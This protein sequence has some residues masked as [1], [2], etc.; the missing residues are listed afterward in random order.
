MDPVECA[1]P[2]SQ[3]ASGTDEEREA[4]WGEASRRAKGFNVRWRDFM[5]ATSAVVQDMLA[6]GQYLEESKAAIKEKGGDWLDVFDPQKVEEPITFG[7][8]TRQAAIRKA[9]SLMLIHRYRTQLLSTN[10]SNLP[11]HISG[12]SGLARVEQKKPGTLAKAAAEGRIFADM[13]ERHVDDLRFDRSELWA[14]LQRKEDKSA[15]AAPPKVSQMT[16]TERAL[17]R[18]LERNDEITEKH[19]ALTLD[20]VFVRSS[21]TCTLCAQ[22]HWLEGDLQQEG[23]TQWIKTH[24][25]GTHPSDKDFVAVRYVIESR[26]PPPARPYDYN[27]DDNR[28]QREFSQETGLFHAF[29][30]QPLA[31]P[32]GS[33]EA[34]AQH[35]DPKPDSNVPYSECTGSHM[36][37]AERE[38]ADID[39]TDEQAERAALIIQELFGLRDRPSVH[40][41][42]CAA[43]NARR[44]SLDPSLAAE[45]RRGWIRFDNVAP[46]AANG[47]AAETE[48]H[49]DDNDDARGM[50]AVTEV[51][52]SHAPARPE[53]SEECSCSTCSDFRA[54]SNRPAKS[55]RKTKK[56]SARSRTGEARPESGEDIERSS[57]LIDV[58][59]GATEK[60]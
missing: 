41:V 36:E 12:M 49:A 14:L 7:G 19:T 2:E 56:R 57:D 10:L 31:L 5:A 43:W 9:E 40:E 58:L 8:L 42:R 60:P 3:Q 54:G 27:S 1:E 23:V 35:V 38:R 34:A 44:S 25:A 37:P 47:E 29:L 15:A 24:I 22:E 48:A 26:L 50:R 52:Q 28:R 53:Q 59:M 32:P 11:P 21:V 33:V 30:M 39:E 13:T 16:D 17:R 55:R 18:E 45:Q 6:M 20:G 51:E 46:N 4:S